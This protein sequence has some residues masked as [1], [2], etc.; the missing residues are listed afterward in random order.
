MTL[1]RVSNFSLTSSAFKS[2]YINIP[3]CGG[4][5]SGNIALAS[6]EKSSPT[7]PNLLLPQRHFTNQ[8][9]SSLCRPCLSRLQAVGDLCF[10]QGYF[11]RLRSDKFA[12]IISPLVT[13][14]NKKTKQFTLFHCQSRKTHNFPV[15]HS[16]VFTTS[17]WFLSS[18]D[19]HSFSFGSIL[20]EKIYA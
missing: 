1:D 5:L 18:P 8:R 2:Y 13:Y 10:L 19:I 20:H 9:N 15:R 4:T 14:R 11:H 7:T 12:S 3:K 17:R 16:F 6:L